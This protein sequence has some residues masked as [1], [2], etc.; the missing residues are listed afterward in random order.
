MTTRFGPIL[1]VRALALLTAAVVLWHAATQASGAAETWRPCFEQSYE[2]A[3]CSFQQYE[4]EPASW[5]RL[6]W[7]WWGEMALAV[8]VLVGSWRSR[9]FRRLAFAAAVAV[10]ASN[11]VLD[12]VLTPAFNGGYTSADDSPGF[13]FFGAACLA[14]AGVLFGLVG[15]LPHRRTLVVDSVTSRDEGVRALI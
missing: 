7:L 8:V 14:I 3:V 5:H 6:F 9:H 15:V 2:S 12:Y 1:I 10:L 11:L 4:A 13:G